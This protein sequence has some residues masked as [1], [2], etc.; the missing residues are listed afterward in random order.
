MSTVTLLAPPNHAGSAGPLRSIFSFPV[1]VNEALT[2]LTFWT[3]SPRFDDPDLWWHVKVG[4]IIWNTHQIPQT[5]QFSFT[6]QGHPWI[7]HEWL[8]QVVLY[9]TWRTG[10]Y[11][12]LL[13]W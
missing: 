13:L 12:A 5:D 9:L 3:C 7:A 10:G 8:S 2:F 4:Q 6:A 1:M 11:S